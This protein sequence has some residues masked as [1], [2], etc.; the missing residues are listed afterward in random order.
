MPFDAFDEITQAEKSHTVHEQKEHIAAVKE[1]LGHSLKKGSKIESLQD[2][3]DK[4]ERIEKEQ[5]KSKKLVQISPE[6]I[7][8]IK[9][10]SMHP[11]VRRSADKRPPVEK[12]CRTLFDY[13]DE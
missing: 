12:Y 5:E 2:M 13:T 9:K 10:Y 1:S 8:Q 6:I 3:Y 11:V 4:I 7:D